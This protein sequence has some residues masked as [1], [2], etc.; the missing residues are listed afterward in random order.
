MNRSIRWALAPIL[1][2][3]AFCLAREEY[4]PESQG[5]LALIDL[6]VQDFSRRLGITQEVTFSFMVGNPS[7]V[8]VGRAE[9]DK[10]VFQ[11]LFEEEFLKTLGERDVCAAVAHELGHVW[12]F[13]H[14]PYLQ[15]EALANEYALKLVPQQDLDSLY[16][17]VRLWKQANPSSTPVTAP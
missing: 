10:D 5:R 8:C 9:P 16:E 13:T 3:P 2:F 12:I 14:F 1:L 17:K 7:L 15:T 4:F 11:L 6:I